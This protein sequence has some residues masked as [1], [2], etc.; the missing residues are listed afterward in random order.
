MILNQ[1][2]LPVSRWVFR[3]GCMAVISVALV[4]AESLHT[5][6]LS[7]SWWVKAP[8]AAAFAGLCLIES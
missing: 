6:E 5:V 4:P 3:L 1:N 8:H 2:I 7:A